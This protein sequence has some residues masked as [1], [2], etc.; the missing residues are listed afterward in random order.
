M[1]TANPSTGATENAPATRRIAAID[2]GTNSMRLIVAEAS[3]DGSYRVL[4]DEKEVTRLGRGL[5]DTGQLRQDSMEHSAQVIARMKGI[6]EGYGVPM[7]QLRI[8]GTCAVREATNGPD[9]V[10]LVRRQ[11]G[12]T[13]EP[14]SGEEE[15]RLAHLSAAAAFDLSSV[16]AAVVD[17]GGG[18][19]EMVLSSGGVIDQLCTLPLGAVRL[20]EQFA[21]AQE[22]GDEEIYDEMR[23]YIRRTI[24]QQFGKAPFVPQFIVGTG[25][26]F[27]SLAAISMHRGASTS[28]GGLLPFAVR[29][30]ELQRSEVKHTLEW[31]R[32][33]PVR[34]RLRV[35]GLSPDRTE[36]IIAGLA[37]AEAVMKHLGANTARVHDRGIRDGLLLTMIHDMWPTGEHRFLE[38]VDRIRSAR[39][40]ATACRYEEHHSNHVA[41]LAVSIFDQLT[42]HRPETLEEC[43]GDAGR[44]LLRVAG[45]LHDVGYFINYS[46]HHKHSYHLIVH[47]DIPGFAHRELEI[48]AN[49][50]RYHRRSEPKAR[51][52]NFAKLPPADRRV[53]R[54]LSAI[55][56]IA[57]GLDR[58]HTRSVRSVRLTITGGVATFTL[59]AP[60][61]PA[62]DMW[63]AGRKADLFAKQ[64]DLEPRFQWIGALQDPGHPGRPAT[65]SPATD[66]QG[67]PAL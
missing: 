5:C 42:Q 19:T 45:I 43:G 7:N 1:I 64:F 59:D 16:S 29:G 40:F 20:T 32:Q 37:V 61:E 50:A 10:E 57:D 27:T 4:D 36:I 13:L 49:I 6:A 31:L 44:E 67:A 8:I 30:Y 41:E 12:L 22:P 15:A 3:A 24:R 17:I 54:V 28:S 2:V 35:A 38:P 18:S 56:R 48:I 26:T 65:A 25:G 53:V 39:H 66:L 47:S 33:M 55:L 9:F 62:A 14:I 46:K 11:S 51:H 23:R 34:S 21:G 63:G 60:E 52:P 58:T